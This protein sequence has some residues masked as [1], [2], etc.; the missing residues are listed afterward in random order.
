VIEET[1][2]ANT[3]IVGSVVKTVLAEDDAT[4]DANVTA[5]DTND[6]LKITVTGPSASV[7]WVA[8]VRTVEVGQ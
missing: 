8:F 1:V 5:D 7:R 3:A 2:F 4:W 6:S